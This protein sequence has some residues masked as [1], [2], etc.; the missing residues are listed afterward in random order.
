MITTDT[1]PNV[2]NYM[3]VIEGSDYFGDLDMIIN[4]VETINAIGSSPEI[5]LKILKNT[6]EKGYKLISPLQCHEDIDKYIE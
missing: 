3:R 5:L 4:Y 1:E 6:K 2:I